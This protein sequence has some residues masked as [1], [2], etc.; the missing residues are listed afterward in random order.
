MNSRVTCVPAPTRATF[1]R[2]YVTDANGEPASKFDRLLDPL[3][4][5]FAGVAR[6]GSSNYRIDRGRL[7]L[8]GQPDA[9]WSLES[10]ESR[11]WLD[12]VRA[13][14]VHTFEDVAEI[15]VGIKT[16]ADNVFIRDDWDDEELLCP[17]LTHH[18]AR[19]WKLDAP[20]NTH[21]LYP[22]T[23]DKSG[24]RTPVDLPRYPR[25]AAH[26]DSHRKQLAARK[27]V[28]AAGRQW[29]E[30]WVPQQPRDWPKL[31]IV[32]PDI[33]ESPAFFL[34][35][36]GAIVNGDCYWMTLR[37]GVDPRWLYMLLAVANSSFIERF[38][39]TV[40]HNK[41]YAGRRRFMTQYVRQ[42]PLPGI[43]ERIV[44]LVQQCIAGR[45]EGEPELNSLVASAFS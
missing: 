27:Y 28:A 25:A 40:F 17:L 7:G 43:D 36:S 34:D 15:R 45:T 5:G 37:D 19:K 14:T 35:T 38:Y 2:V 24:K 44:A 8:D 21:V 30:I 18:V 32:W 33:S 31:K 41:L 39:D 4:N 22:H 26:L 20:P 13:R 23:T 3:R 42:F 16:T 6:V 1:S 11:P 9:P 12:R 29:F 10:A